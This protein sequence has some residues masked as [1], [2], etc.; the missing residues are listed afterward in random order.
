MTTTIKFA[1]IERLLNLERRVC[2]IY[3]TL[4]GNE[5]FAAEARAFW[6]DMAEDEK[7]HHIILERSAGLLNFAAEPP[8]LSQAQIQQLQATLEAAEYA[9]GRPEVTSDEALRHALALES[10]ELNQLDDKWLSGFHPKLTS[11]SNALLPAHDIH[12][13]RLADAV[14]KFSADETLHRQARALLSA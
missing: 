8:D 14:A 4:A 10:S 3:Q 1:F 9:C 13:R 2:H 12:L 7:Q 5:S 6:R 11:L